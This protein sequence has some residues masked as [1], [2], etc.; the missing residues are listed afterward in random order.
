MGDVRLEPVAEA[1]KDRLK[2]LLNLYLYGLSDLV[3]ADPD[4]QGR[5][6]YSFLDLYWIE[7]DRHAF[8]IMVDG[9]VGGFVM[10]NAHTFTGGDRSIAEFFVLKRHRRKGVG[11][12]AAVATFDRLPGEWEVWT[13]ANNARGQAFWRATVRAYTDGA[14]EERT[15]VHEGL[16]PVFRF[17]SPPVTAQTGS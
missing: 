1:E 4:E 5:F 3:D 17:T 15:G 2:E 13:D 7:P 8:F 11:A 12:A 10:V 6:E 9:V 14:Y 16:G